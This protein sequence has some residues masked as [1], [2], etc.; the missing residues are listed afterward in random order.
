MTLAKKMLVELIN[1]TNG[2]AVPLRAV[3][4]ATPYPNVDPQIPRDTYC[5]VSGM[6]KE[7]FF[8]HVRYYYNRLDLQ[9]IFNQIQ[10]TLH[11]DVGALTNTHDAVTLLVERY[12]LR[13]E[14][15]DVIQSPIDSNTLPTSFLLQAH[16]K[17]HAWQGQVQVTLTNTELPWLS[18]VVLDTDLGDV[19]LEPTLGG[20]DFGDLELN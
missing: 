13:I 16:P 9:K 15:V 4:I 8:G 17:S 7:G 11:I 2:T 6:F 10:P 12:G 5:V 20:G 18:D 19:N 3:R 14:A 1:R